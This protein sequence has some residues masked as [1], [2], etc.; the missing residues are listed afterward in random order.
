[1]E[2]IKYDKEG[3]Y[4]RIKASHLD[5]SITLSPTEARIKERLRHLYGLRL[6][7][8]AKHQ[9]LQIHCQEM[10]VSEATAYRD[11][12]YAMLIYGELDRADR[13]A[14]RVVLAERYW[15]LY[16]RALKANDLEQARKALD[17]YKSLFNF[18]AEEQQ[19]D[20]EKIQA[21]IYNIRLGRDVRKILHKTIGTGVVDFNALTAEDVDFEEI[22]EQTVEEENSS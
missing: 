22:K 1:M 6:S 17:S 16:Q 20:L 19:I 18:D 4:Q 2:V 9:A 15:D 3:T 21:H 11:Y 7:G 10:N 14:E 8:Y 5:E 12:A 13:N